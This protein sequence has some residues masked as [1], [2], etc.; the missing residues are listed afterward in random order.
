MSDDKFESLE[1][2]LAA[3]LLWSP[4]ILLILFGGG[5]LPLIMFYHFLIFFTLLKLSR[6]GKQ[7]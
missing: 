2:F 6:N 4:N 3:G 7:V 5:Y 1:L